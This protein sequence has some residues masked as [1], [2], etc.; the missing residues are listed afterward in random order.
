[1]REWIGE[2]FDP[3]A[4]NVEGLADDVAALAETWARRPPAKR[5][6]SP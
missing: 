3:K 6:T 1:M 5:K 2:T 4:V